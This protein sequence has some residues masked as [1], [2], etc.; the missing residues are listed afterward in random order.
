MKFTLSLNSSGYVVSPSLYVSYTKLSIQNGAVT[1]SSASTQSIT[2]Q[3][4]FV[5]SL[6]SFWPPFI[7]IFITINVL[8]LI[9]SLAR[10]YIAYLNRQSFLGF[11]Y[12]LANFWSLWMFYFLIAISGYWF[13]FCKTTQGVYIFIPD[14]DSDFFY[15]AF[16]IIAGLMGFFRLATVL[17]DKK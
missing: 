7:G 17:Y 13:L 2:Y 1:P 14:A 8:V 3:I 12:Y 9:Q 16:Y 11:F 6:S 10:T 4:K 5:Y 15:A